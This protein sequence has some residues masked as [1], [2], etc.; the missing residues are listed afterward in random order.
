MQNNVPTD[1]EIGELWRREYLPGRHDIKLD[2][3]RKVAEERAKLIHSAVWANTDHNS[4]C[5]GNCDRR[6]RQELG[7]PE[8]TWR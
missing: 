7:I 4:N 6:A 1:K 8:D 3:I 5:I 2:L